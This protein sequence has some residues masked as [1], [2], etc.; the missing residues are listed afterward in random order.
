MLRNQEHI[1]GHGY[2]VTKLPGQ[3]I[4]RAYDEH[5]HAQARAEE[6]HFFTSQSPWDTEWVEFQSRF[7]TSKLAHALSQKFA[8]QIVKR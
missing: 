6:E 7:G 3:S 8:A 1:V 4:R 5:Y 2:Y